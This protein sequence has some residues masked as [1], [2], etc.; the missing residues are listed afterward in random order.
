MQKPCCCQVF[1]FQQRYSVGPTLPFVWNPFTHCVE[2]VQAF[3]T[4]VRGLLLKHSYYLG[5]SD[6]S[7]MRY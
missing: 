5:T 1:Y 4:S 7:E 2:P 3:F 6:A